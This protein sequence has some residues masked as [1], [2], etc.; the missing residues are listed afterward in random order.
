M[1]L[2]QKEHELMALYLELKEQEE[3]ELIVEEKKDDGTSTD[4]DG[5]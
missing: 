5:K 2:Y 1:Y 3:K 4:K